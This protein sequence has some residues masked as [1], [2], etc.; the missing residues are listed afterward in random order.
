MGGLFSGLRY[1]DEKVVDGTVVGAANTPVAGGRALR[2][3]QT[4]QL[5]LY[6]VFIGVGI[7]AIALSVY[8]FS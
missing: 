5:Q 8:F 6:G 2:Y 4:G 1:F 3:T 7:L